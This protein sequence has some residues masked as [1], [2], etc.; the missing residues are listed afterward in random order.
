MNPHSPA[1]SSMQFNKRTL[2]QK[3]TAHEV[4]LALYNDPNHILVAWFVGKAPAPFGGNIDMP[5][6]ANEVYQTLCESRGI[7]PH[8]V[9]SDA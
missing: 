3:A 6:V 4:S 7:D 5:D 2:A 1:I 9:W 8:V